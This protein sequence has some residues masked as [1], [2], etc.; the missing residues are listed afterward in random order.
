MEDIHTE[1]EELNKLLEA[2]VTREN[3][4]EVD[5]EKVN[6]K[7]AELIEKV[8]SEAT[9]G[10]SQDE[11]EEMRS[12]LEKQLRY[13]YKD[14]IESYIAVR[15]EDKVNDIIEEQTNLWKNK[16]LEQRKAEL[17][18]DEA[19]EKIISASNTALEMAKE[20]IKKGKI[21]TDE[22]L[23]NRLKNVLEDTTKVKE[24]NKKKIEEDVSEG[25][26]D[27]DFAFGFT[28]CTS[29]RIGRYR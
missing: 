5:E 23:Y 20:R 2:N 17:L 25:L 15:M 10:V 11:K 14:S 12:K 27:L 24:F 9:K 16:S 4:G 8:T 19:K 29:L 28:E 7:M 1:I 18:R 3:T 22:E 13:V 26:V 6:E 21:Q